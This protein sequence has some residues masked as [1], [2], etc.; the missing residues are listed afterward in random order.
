L[1]AFFW[2][3]TFSQGQFG[4]ELSRGAA[5]AFFWQHGFAFFSGCFA[6]AW[7]HNPNGIIS[8]NAVVKRTSF[9]KID[10]MV[11]GYEKLGLFVSSIRE[12]I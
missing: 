4:N 6:A 2:Q 11:I 5:G 8:N 3:Q 10:F 1:T 12:R 9:P 7:Q